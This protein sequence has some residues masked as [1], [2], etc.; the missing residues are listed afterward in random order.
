MLRR[1]QHGAHGIRHLVLHQVNAVLPKRNQL[2]LN[3][4]PDTD[5]SLPPLLE[6]CRDVEGRVVVLL[7]DPT[8]AVATRVRESLGAR[9]RVLRRGSAAAAWQ[10]LR[11][12]SVVFTHPVHGG[13]RLSPRQTVVDIWHGMPIKA[14]GRLDGPQD[15][16]LADLTLASSG[17]FR[18]FM[19]AALGVPPQSVV[20]LNSPRIEQ[21]CRAHPGVW[22][23]LGIDRARYDRVLVWMPTFRGREPE[24]GGAGVRSA[25]LL[26]AKGTTR[27][28]EVLA[29]R[30]CLL[31]LRRHPYEAQT[32][33][34]SA[35]GVVELTDAVLEAV[36]VGVYEVLAEA[37]GLITDVS[38]VWLDYLLL[39]RP[40]V[41][42]FPDVDDYTA[43][44]QLVLDPYDA[45][46]PGPVLDDEDDLLA[47]VDAVAA[48]EDAHRP[49]RRE[50]R[51]ELMGDDV[52]D[53]S[54]RVLALAGLRRRP[55]SSPD[56]DSGR[57]RPGHRGVV[58]RIR[59]MV[60]VVETDGVRGR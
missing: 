23:Q 3:L 32:A 6:A 47:A 7:T 35:P 42:W 39:D 45:W 12:R 19:A 56:A 4:Y 36:G 46:T 18:P 54:A 44:R 24:R 27:L 48:G 41:I 40:I 13:G 26:S 30:R 10:Y 57:L 20:L 16:V 8:N 51:R 28:A 53:L 33:P 9:V 37:D 55:A 11:S 29:R 14:I 15:A 34:V 25:P 22:Q 21:L 2:L 43:D 31:V 59:S 49:R 58:E 38:S 17:F 50:V 1:L 52:E 5:A 60:A